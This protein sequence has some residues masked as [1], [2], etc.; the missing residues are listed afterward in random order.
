MNE[1]EIQGKIYISS[2]RAAEV[3]GYAKDY[4][5][6]L[7]R[8]NKI[9][10]T[11]IGKAWYVD[12]D[13]IKS[14][15]GI[16]DTS[17]PQPSPQGDFRALEKS[18]EVKQERERLRSLNSLRLS[19][20]GADLLK[21]WGELT[22][23]SDESDLFPIPNQNLVTPRNYQI[24]IKKYDSS[25][26]KK[27]DQ[28]IQTSEV[29]SQI[30]VHIGPNTKS[31]DGRDQK[32]V[33][34]PSKDHVRTSTAPNNFLMLG[35]GLTSTLVLIV[36]PLISSLYIQWHFVNSPIAAASTTS[37]QM[38][39]EPIFDYFKGI[40]DAGVMLIQ[41]FLDLLVNSIAE[42]FDSGLDFLIDFF[43]LV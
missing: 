15:A 42:F 34:I 21:T 1:I 28:D 41:G 4:I 11:R 35:T 16:A 33:S 27:S 10:A 17:T 31:I 2:K 24:T 19:G 20:S 32:Y 7:A 37:F 13:A 5:G 6:Q 40:F 12:L 29:A 26:N 9:P 39:F 30:P 23:S 25:I 36:F 14:H 22:Y 38:E 8:E 3:T 18:L 43:N